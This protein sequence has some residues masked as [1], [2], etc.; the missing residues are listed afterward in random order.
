[1]GKFRIQ[2]MRTAAAMTAALL[3]TFIFPIVDSDWGMSSEAAARRGRSTAATSRRGRSSAASGRS[4]SG[5]GRSGIPT[6]HGRYHGVRTHARRAAPRPKYAYPLEFFSYKTSDYDHSPLPDDV[7]AKVRESFANGTADIYPPHWLVRAGVAKH[8]PLRGGI[9]KRRERIKYIILHSTESGVPQDAR[10]VVDAWS[11]GGRRHPGTQYIIDRDGGILQPVHPDWGAVHVNIFKTL[12]GINNDN[13]VGIEMCHW[14]QIGYPAEQRLAAKRLITYLQ[15]RYH[16]LDENIITHRY[17]QQGDHT[18][19][20]AFDF[21][22]FLATKDQFRTAAI[23]LKKPTPDE[24]LPEFDFP[25]A[26]VYMEIHGP[27]SDVPADPPADKQSSKGKSSVLD[28]TAN[29]AVDGN[30]Q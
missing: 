14:G 25:T 23:A 20:V 29:R 28:E 18:D 15:D 16:I 19:P 22:A 13:T 9:F 5:R 2:V 27:F 12:P 26:S 10:H 4:R 17:A 3:A 8:Y 7:A 1:M 11:S 30:S 21:E 6:H 24:D